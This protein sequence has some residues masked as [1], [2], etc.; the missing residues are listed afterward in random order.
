MVSGKLETEAPGD[1]AFHVRGATKIYR[2]GCWEAIGE[3]LRAPGWD[4]VDEYE[5][6]MLGWAYLHLSGVETLAS[7]WPRE[8]AQGTWKNWVKNGLANYVAGYHPLFMT[9]KCIQRIRHRP[10]GVAACGLF[11]GF[12]GGYIAC[13][14]QVDDRRLIEYVRDQQLRRLSLRRSLWTRKPNK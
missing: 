10:Y 6:N 4:T 7:P 8:A 14:P 12:L 9:F 2:R 3:L 5:A 1:P 13:V 11:V